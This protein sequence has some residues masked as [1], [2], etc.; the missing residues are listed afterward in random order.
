MRA[1][2]IYLYLCYHQR[3]EIHKP[4]RNGRLSLYPM[5]F[6]DAIRAIAKVNPEPRKPKKL[7]KA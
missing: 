7:R 4:K 2:R 5:K 6:E 3:M 1:A